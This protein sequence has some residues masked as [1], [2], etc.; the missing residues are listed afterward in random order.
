MNFNEASEKG[1]TALR[2]RYLPATIIALFLILSNCAHAQVYS[3]PNPGYGYHYKRMMFDSTLIIPT[4]CGVPTLR[5]VVTNKA[6]IAFDSCNAK[7]YV[8]NPKL[9][10]WSEVTGSGG[11][12]TVKYSLQGYGIVLDSTTSTYTITLDTSVIANA[13]TGGNTTIFETVLDSTGQP[14]NRVLFSRGTKIS[15]S[16]RFLF[17]TTNSKLVIN[18]NNISAGG[19]NT[20][21]FVQGNQ[22]T[23]GQLTV[24]NVVA[25]GD[26]TSNKPVVITTGGLINK[27]N[28]WPVVSDPAK[29]NISDTASML[30]GYQRDLALTTTG[31]SGA[32]TLVGNTLNIPQYAGGS[33]GFPVLADI[34]ALELYSGSETT[35]IVS[36]TLRGGVFNYTTG[37]Q[38]PDSGT[39]FPAPGKGSGY[40]LRQMAEQDK[41]YVTWYGAVHDSLTDD[42]QPIQLAINAAATKDHGT[43]Y[44]PSGPY[45]INGPIITN[46][47]GYDP[48]SQLYMPVHGDIRLRKNI[49][50]LGEATLNKSVYSHS[51]LPAATGARLYSNYSGTR[52]TTVPGTAIIGG[53]GPNIGGVGNGETFIT[54]MVENIQFMPL[55]NPNGAGPEI[56]G[57]NGRH[58]ASIKV[59]NSNYV[60]NTSRDS[61]VPPTRDI[62]G[63]ETSDCNNE[64]MNTLN[65]VV[66]FGVKR[67]FVFGEHT[68]GDQIDAELCV[69][70]I[71][72]KKGN[73]ASSFNR[74]LAQNCRYP[75]GYYDNG[76][77][78]QTEICPVNITLLDIEW[79]DDYYPG[80]YYETIY[81]IND[82][83][84]LLTGNVRYWVTE[85]GS[86]GDGNSLWTVN[87]ATNIKAFKLGDGSPGLAANN[88]FSGTN[89]FTG[90]NTNVNNPFNVTVS[91]TN[92]ISL[93]GT[94]ANTARFYNNTTNSTAEAD[95]IFEND[96]GSFASYGM[97]LYG[98]S[99]NPNSLFGL[100]RADRLML[101][102]DGANNEGMV[103]G[104]LSAKPFSIGTNS[105]IKVIIPSNYDTAP[106]SAS[107]T[108]T[109]GEIRVTSTHAY[110][111]VA[112]NT[113][114]RTALS[115]W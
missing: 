108:G 24:Q 78:C 75:L 80:K 3:N 115:T 107:A 95:M 91:G 106:A 9:T 110:Y 109:T 36:D 61:L 58:I 70:G 2:N 10:T 15:S 99:A 68:T 16:P 32:A 46:V 100:S 34:T 49:K 8:Y 7:F 23:T 14:N 21:L 53:D 97:M 44:F 67:G 54:L 81:G 85:A 6:A 105:T 48:N 101:F 13:S 4:V 18:H 56:G 19:A 113:W 83:L 51:S 71:A 25:T 38:T 40:W 96:R 79:N 22:T 63:F 17:D 47:G 50:L 89:T 26:T 52:S 94:G 112:T 30:A 69:W 86:G 28:R 65:N 82:S 60:P 104:T 11:G 42:T 84:N 66:A 103:V 45:A 5:S 77:G 43:V 92:G 87:G 102:A 98:S 74:V 20:K 62:A 39:V 73:H 59:L 12:G 64:I 27:L 93:T 57:V 35:V 1:F 90:A 114:V 55:P 111:C 33:G 88:T 37:T 76:S 29:V 72:G 31:S 41:Y